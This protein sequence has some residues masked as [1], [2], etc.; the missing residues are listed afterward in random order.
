[1][2]TC[3]CVCMYVCMY[4]RTYVCMYVCMYTQVVYIHCNQAASCSQI[5]AAAASQALEAHVGL[6]ILQLLSAIVPNRMTV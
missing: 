1:M 3:M 2:Y 5:H 4:V 6:S